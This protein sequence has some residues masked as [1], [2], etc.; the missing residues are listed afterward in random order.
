[1][2]NDRKVTLPIPFSSLPS[3]SHSWDIIEGI[4]CTQPGLGPLG[5]CRAMMREVGGSSS[6]RLWE[7]RVAE[8]Q[9]GTEFKK[10][11]PE[12]QWDCPER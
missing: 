2:R 7:L 9:V 3:P 12:L 4:L 11:F 8:T 5:D 1:M 6:V 10:L